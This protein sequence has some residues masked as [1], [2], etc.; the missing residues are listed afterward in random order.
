MKSI[1]LKL[2]LQDRDTTW[3][4]DSIFDA[5]ED[6]EEIVLFETTWLDDEASIYIKFKAYH[7]LDWIPQLVKDQLNPGERFLEAQYKWHN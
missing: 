1:L 4:Y 7:Q 6:D 2:K 3:V 5:L